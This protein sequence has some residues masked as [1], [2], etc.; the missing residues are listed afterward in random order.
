[1]SK[2]KKV[3]LKDDEQ[4]VLE[5]LKSNSNKSINKIAKNCGFSRQKVWRI[6][7]KF[8]KENRVW[9]YTAVV[10]EESENLNYYILL[11][12][13]DSVPIPKTAIKNIVSREIDDHI[14]KINCSMVTSLYTNGHYDWIIIFTAPDIIKAKKVSE[15]FRAR[16]KDILKEVNLLETIF[17]A[18]VQGIVNPDIGELKNFF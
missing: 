14:R 10:D 11:L 9:G 18:K 1:M 4:K 17:P 12:K 7:K 6:I 5:E 3:H 13:R 8:E 15:L 16:Y 2:S